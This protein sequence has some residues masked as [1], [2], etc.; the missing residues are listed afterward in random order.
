MLIHNI[1]L[2]AYRVN[3]LFENTLTIPLISKKYAIVFHI[4]YFGK[5]D[6]ASANQAM[7]FYLQLISYEK[8]A[9]RPSDKYR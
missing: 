4:I 8:V 6:N 5:A 9:V 2:F 1:H 3:R 7:S